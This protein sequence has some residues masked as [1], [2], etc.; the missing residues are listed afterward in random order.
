MKVLQKVFLLLMLA[1]AQ[2]EKIM[3]EII[4]L[5]EF[6]DRFVETARCGELC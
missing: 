6:T 1:K 2:P 3:L 4:R 5:V